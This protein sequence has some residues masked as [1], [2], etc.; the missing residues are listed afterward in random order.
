MEMKFAINAGTLRHL[1]FRQALKLSSEGGFTGF[2]I[3]LSQIEEFA[4]SSNDL[5]EI[6]RFIKSS[7]VSIAEVGHIR[8]WLSAEGEKWKICLQESERLF[9]FSQR[10]NSKFVTAV[11]VDCQGEFSRAVDNFSELCRIAKKYNQNVGIEY[12]PFKPDVNSITAAWDIVKASGMENGGVVVDAFHFFKGDSKLSDLENLPADKIYAVH[13]CDLRKTS[14]EETQDPVCQ[15]REMRTIPGQGYFDLQV[16]V[17]Q[18]LEIGYEGFFSLEI[19]SKEFVDNKPEEYLR[20]LRMS[21][22]EI[23]ALVNEPS[24]I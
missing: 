24:V 21:S 18:L 4:D 9:K 13:L 10:V 20:R 17:V 7:G 12:F 19:L 14:E 2:G 6:V 3:W 11:V 16:F 1:P 23:C 8:N 15:A 22:E 5:E